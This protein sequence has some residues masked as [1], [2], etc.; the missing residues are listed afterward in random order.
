MRPW[1]HPSCHLRSLRFQPDLYGHRL[2]FSPLTPAVNP[3]SNHNCRFSAVSGG[4]P[5][6]EV[7]SNTRAVISI[8]NIMMVKSVLSFLIVM[9]WHCI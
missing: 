8:T 3:S 1:C 6:L 4:F 5:P 9:I 7:S 2:R